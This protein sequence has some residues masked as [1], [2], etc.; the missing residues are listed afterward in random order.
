MN[1]KEFIIVLVATFIAVMVWLVADI[2]FNTKASV[3]ISPK[4]Q[5]LLEPI[6]PSFDGRI[7]EQ[8]KNLPDIG[9]PQPTA[10]SSSTPTP[11]PTAL[12]SLVPG[13]L[14]VLPDSELLSTPSAQ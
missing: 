11:L 12:P 6:S 7:L 2:L 13:V 1:K 3:P 10:S 9:R 4:L 5:S 8:V 14:N